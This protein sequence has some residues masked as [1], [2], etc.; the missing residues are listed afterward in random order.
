MLDKS[1]G[2][3][4]VPQEILDMMAYLFKVGVQGDARP[5]I[6]IDLKTGPGVWY[7]WLTSWDQ[8]GCVARSFVHKRDWDTDVTAL[9]PNDVEPNMAYIVASDCPGDVD[10]GKKLYKKHFLS[11]PPEKLSVWTFKG[12]IAHASLLLLLTFVRIGWA[13][14]FKGPGVPKEVEMFTAWAAIIL[15]CTGSFLF[16]FTVVSNA[17]AAL[18]Y[19]FNARLLM[20]R[21]DTPFKKRS[22]PRRMLNGLGFIFLVEFMFWPHGVKI[23]SFWILSHVFPGI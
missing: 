3:E 20:W 22:I 21:H 17:Y 19:L 4:K 6:E 1:Y 11:A 13:G 8:A 15:V 2:V 14:F 23:M 12:L 16:S 5:L 10:R 7:H 9:K 18:N